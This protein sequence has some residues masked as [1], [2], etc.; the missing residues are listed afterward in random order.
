MGRK[1]P[2]YFIQILFIEFIYLLVFPLADT[3]RSNMLGVSDR[4]LD[5]NI[6]FKKEKKYICLF[7]TLF[8]CQV[9]VYEEKIPYDKSVT[10]VDTIIA[11]LQMKVGSLPFNESAL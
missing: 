2:F 4:R 9:I 7:F 10:L 8:Y 3:Q 1:L 11:N 6:N 5:E